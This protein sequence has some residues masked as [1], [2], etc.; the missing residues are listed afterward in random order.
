MKAVLYTIGAFIIFALVAFLITLVP[1]PPTGP[2]LFAIWVLFAIP[3]LGAFWMMYMAARYERDP[4]S[5]I[6]LAIFIPFTFVWYYF[7]RV[8]PRGVRRIRNLQVADKNGEGPSRKE[9]RV[10]TT[11]LLS[12]FGVVVYAVA[13]WVMFTPGVPSRF[14]LLVPLA[15]A[16][17]FIHP[18]GA[19]WM[20]Y[21]VVRH[22]KR[23]FPLLLLA[24]AP[25][26]FL[27][28]YFDRV[29]SSSY[30]SRQLA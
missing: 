26:G 6:L 8:R 20:V 23:V 17:F 18:I 16:V 1:G 5:L 15:G 30:K 21:M 29:R 9:S 19:W 3:P 28:Y 7:E 2:V 25:L 4:V 27:W 10:I 12:I 24:F 11:A 22:E 13:F 14:P